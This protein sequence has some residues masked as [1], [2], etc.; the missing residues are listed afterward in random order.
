MSYQELIALTERFL[1]QQDVRSVL[2]DK[3][4]RFFASEALPQPKK[5]ESTPQPLFKKSPEKSAP[6][7]VAAA[8]I[9]KAAPAPVIAAP[10]APKPQGI[11]CLPRP[12]ARA[13]RPL[14]DDIKAAI[15]IGPLVKETPDDS[16]AREKERAWATSAPPIILFSFF[17]KNSPKAQ[18]IETICEAISSRL[19]R[20]K[21]YHLPDLEE[22][23]ESYILAQNSCLKACLFASDL[24]SQSKVNEFLLPLNLEADVRSNEL[25]YKRGTLYQTALFDICVSDDL[26]TNTEQKKKLWSEI[27]NALSN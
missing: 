21:L 22:L 20:C 16:T 9:K 11:P 15:K 14:F 24:S 3:E 4:T 5:T 7:P 17:P 1:T 23:T 8:P 26:A 10:V 2:L 13:S 27:K 12:F 19:S 18:F 6:T 25:F